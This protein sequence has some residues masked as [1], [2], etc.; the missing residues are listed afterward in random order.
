MLRI[1]AHAQV[2]ARVS[3]E[4]PRRAGDRLPAD[5]QEPVE[6]LLEAMAANRVDRAVLVQTGGRALEHHAYLRHC[7]RRYPGRFLGIG[8]I[9]A[10]GVSPRE[11][12][13]HMD[14]LA[15]DGDVIGFRLSSL[16]GP[17]DPL[18]AMDVRTFATYPI[19][20]H[21]AGKDYVLWLCPH[22]VDAHTVPFLIDAFPNVRVVFNRML[23]CPG[24]GST[25][26]DEKGR[27]RVELSQFPP[28]TRYSTMGLHQYG[29]AN[30]LLS[31]QYAFSNEEWPYRDLTE[32]HERLHAPG[33][34][35]QGFGADRLMW[36]SD[37]PSIAEDPGYDR[38]VRVV[39]ELLPGLSEEE[40]S[41]IMGGT[42]G[43]LLKF[44]GLPRQ[45][46]HPRAT[47]EGEKC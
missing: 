2:F 10:G 5:R 29:N 38:M 25:G 40:L 28:L 26:T 24:A 1:D 20:K 17:A 44:P 27:P 42:A 32:W 6:K 47:G 31:G 35:L 41:A 23:A 43:R 39:G 34:R 13:D 3:R 11:Q 30:V 36:G 7:L 45:R 46:P 22:A 12:T 14:R 16:G 8:R 21:A 37:F 4:F 9:P 19:W 15:A 18:A 33:R